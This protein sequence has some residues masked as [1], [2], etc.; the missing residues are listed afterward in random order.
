MQKG[1]VMFKYVDDVVSEINS[2]RRITTRDQAFGIMRR[3][4]LDDFGE[5]LL[6]MPSKDFPRASALLPSMASDAI[7]RSWTGTDGYALL[8]QSCNFVRALSYNF[9]RLTGRPLSDIRVLDYGCGYGRIAR[10]MYYFVDSNDLV[11]VDPWD[12]S[13]SECKRARLGDNF[14]LSDYLPTSLPLKSTFALAYAFSVFTHLS[15]RAARMAFATVRHYTNV[16]G[17]FCITIRPAEYWDIDASAAS[18]EQRLDMKAAHLSRGFAFCPHNLP[19]IDGDLTYGDTSVS[20]EWLARNIPGWR[21]VAI[22]R[23]LEDP[24]QIYVFLEAV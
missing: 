23:S 10:L 24:Y 20:L 4:G 5:I 21:Q 1:P 13:I 12:A 11:G 7:Q 18:A 9:A 3:L 16:G 17:M 8:R 2:N 14:L 6:N 15:E 22:D 19:P